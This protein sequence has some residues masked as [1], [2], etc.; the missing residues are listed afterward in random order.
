[1]YSMRHSK[2]RET[3][4]PGTDRKQAVQHTAHH[5]AES[6]LTESSSLFLI[7]QFRQKDST[8]PRGSRTGW[9]RRWFRRR[10]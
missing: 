2:V 6:T 5:A 3:P 10:D 8:R 4:S 1:M 9:W 7:H